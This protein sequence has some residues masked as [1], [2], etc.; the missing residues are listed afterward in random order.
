MNWRIMAAIRYKKKFQL[1]TAQD[2]NPRNTLGAKKFGEALSRP[3]TLSFASGQI[4]FHLAVTSH[5]QVDHY[6]VGPHRWL[7]VKFGACVGD[8][9][10]MDVIA[11]AI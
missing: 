3:A 1:S 6:A 8:L 2:S 5:G 11:R 10:K 7:P 4:N 9:F